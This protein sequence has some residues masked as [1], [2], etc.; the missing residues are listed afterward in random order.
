MK[1]LKLILVLFLFSSNSIDAQNWPQIGQKWDYFNNGFNANYPMVYR[2]IYESDTLI[3][4]LS[5]MKIQSHYKWVIGLE[6]G[7]TMGLSQEFLGDSILWQWQGDTLLWSN[8]INPQDQ[9]IL[10]IMNAQPGDTWLFSTNIFE[11]ECDTSYVTVDSIGSEVVNGNTLHWLALRTDIP[12]TI[13]LNGKLVEGYGLVDG[14]IMGTGLSCA[15]NFD[16]T[17]LFPDCYV[18]PLYGN[19]Y[20]GP[21]SCYVYESLSISDITNDSSIKVF[22]NP[23]SGNISVQNRNSSICTVRLFSLNGDLIEEFLANPGVSNF[24]VSTLSNGLYLIQLNTANSTYF[25]KHAII[26]N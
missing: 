24:D 26:N 5:Y 13:G 15:G 9:N 2:Y 3:N 23:S 17:V 7:G 16:Y 11:G 8:V 18:S 10:C 12:S 6:P 22:P 19:Y 25:Q 20:L 21:N 14:F 1:T 4:G